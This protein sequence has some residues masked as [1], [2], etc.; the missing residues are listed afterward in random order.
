MRDSEAMTTTHPYF[1][2]G[3][4]LSG[5]I[6]VPNTFG[7]ISL[8]IAFA[9]GCFF[10]LGTALIVANWVNPNLK[11][12]D[13]G[14]ILWF[15]LCGMIHLFFEGYFVLNHNHMASRTDFFGELW[16]EYSLSDS[17]YL[18]SDPFVLCMETWTAITWGPL[19]FLTA[20]LIT[21]DSPYRHPVQA[22]VSTGQF[23]GDLLYYM[24]SLFDYFYSGKSFYRPEPYYFW[25]YFI[26]MNAF[27]IVI[28]SIVLKLQR[29]LLRFPKGLKRTG[30]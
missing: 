12:S 26:F 6:Y 8:V 20:V 7:A 13:R 1:P 14:L 21:K 24:T 17:R 2:E 16:K 4:L 5:G 23:Y 9:G 18:F 25:F 29:E 19:S 27:W 10:I 30:M 11:T 15:T 3:L 22:L 28:P